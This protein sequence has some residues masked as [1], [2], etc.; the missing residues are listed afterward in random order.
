MKQVFYHH[1]VGITA[2]EEIILACKLKRNY[3]MGQQVRGAA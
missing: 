2:L 3:R 1:I